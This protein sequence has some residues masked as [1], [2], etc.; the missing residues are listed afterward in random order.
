MRYTYWAV[1]IV[2]YIAVFLV[3]N[4][5]VREACTAASCVHGWYSKFNGV[6][7]AQ[8]IAWLVLAPIAAWLVSRA[9]FE[10]IPTRWGLR[11]AHSRF[12]VVK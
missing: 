7:K 9:L 8:A 3:L 2:A 4:D 11:R 6:E 1:G 10:V 5:R 12:R